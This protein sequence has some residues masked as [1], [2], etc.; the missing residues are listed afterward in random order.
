MHNAPDEIESNTS[1]N[2]HFSDVLAVN[3]HRRQLLQGGFALAATTLLAGTSGC[4]RTM[5][6][7]E[8]APTLGFQ[9]IAASVADELRVAPGYSARLLYG[10][11]DPISNGPAMKPDASDSAALQNAAG[12]HASRWYAF[13]SVS[14]KG[15]SRPARDQSRIHRRRLIA[16]RRHDAM[17][18]GESREIESRAW[19]IGHRSEVRK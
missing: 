3:L 9:A 16:C 1:A 19:R 10:W 2:E 6:K 5:T 8:A 17:D 7:P 13:F 14:R 15:K 4:A 18:G 11:G 12:G